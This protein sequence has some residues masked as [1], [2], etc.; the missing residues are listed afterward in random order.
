MI[1]SI[2]VNLPVQDLAR[3]RTF[4]TALGFTFNESFSDDKALC[5]ILNE[6]RI[7]SMLI[8]K[9]FFTNFT[10]RT[11]A[12]G[13]TTQVLIAIEVHSRE[14]VDQLVLMALAQGGNRYRDSVDYGW[15]YYDSFT[16]PDGHQW[17]VLYTDETK[18][19]A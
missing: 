14:Q 12:D 3:S 1:K 6:G 18:I 13:S 9:D 10:D 11:V 2:Y 7:Y 17:E 19:N 5:L 16:D 15:M 4:W 8:R